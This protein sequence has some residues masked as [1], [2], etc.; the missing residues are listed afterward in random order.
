MLTEESDIRSQKINLDKLF[1]D[2]AKS[3]G[4]S[5]FKVQLTA[6]FEKFVTLLDLADE[7]EQEVS[8]RERYQV[9]Y[10]IVEESSILPKI[11]PRFYS[12]ITEPFK[13]DQEKTDRLEIVFSLTQFFKGANKGSSSSSSHSALGLC[14]SFLSDP[15]NMSNPDV[16]I[17]AQFSS[18]YRVLKLPP[19]LP[20]STRN[21][22]MIGQGTGIAPFLSMLDR[23]KSRGLTEQYK[24]VLLFGVRDDKE[25][26]IF[27]NFLTSFF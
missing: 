1:A 13:S 18:A 12:I 5:E 23:I 7:Y 9:P 15:T 20:S 27:S 8:L 21:V 10:F 19:S 24:I 11:R 25:S 16:Q 17:K 3:P 4:I 2:S 6:K 26:F 22:L 14:T